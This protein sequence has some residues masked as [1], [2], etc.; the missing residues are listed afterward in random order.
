M[1]PMEM[2]PPDEKNIIDMKRRSSKAARRFDRI[3]QA[4]AAIHSLQFG[5]QI[6]VGK[7]EKAMAGE[8]TSQWMDLSSEY[9]AIKYLPPIE[10]K[11]IRKKVK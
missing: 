5:E 8:L 11:K 10:S 9:T 4:T 1:Q 6:N 7:Y 2:D 3:V